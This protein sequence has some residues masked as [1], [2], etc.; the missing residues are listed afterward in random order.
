MYK[1]HA[2]KCTKWHARKCTKEDKERD[3]GRQGNVQRQARKGTKAG[4][5]ITKAGKERYE[6]VSRVKRPFFYS[7][8]GSVINL[9]KCIEI[10]Y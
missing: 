7:I 2:R 8:C 6:L 10:T 4:K 5:E 3:K 9:S 1:W